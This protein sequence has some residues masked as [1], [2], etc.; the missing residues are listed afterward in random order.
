[1]SATE[2]SVDDIAEKVSDAQLDAA[3]SADEPEAEALKAFV[4]RALD[5]YVH[6]IAEEEIGISWEEDLPDL[7]VMEER[8]RRESNFLRAIR[9]AARE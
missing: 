9:N 1:M 3:I 4:E 5:H 8:S 6:M 2:R 7:A